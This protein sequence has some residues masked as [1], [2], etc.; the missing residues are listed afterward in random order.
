MLQILIQANLRIQEHEQDTQNFLARAIHDFR[1]PLTSISGY[2][3]LLLEEA[4]GPVTKE[5]QKVLT[6]MQ[7][8]AA[9]LAALSDGIFQL[10]VQHPSLSTELKLEGADIRDCLDRALQEVAPLVE[11]KCI[12]VKVDVTPPPDG[13]VFERLQIEQALLNLLIN[14]CRFTPRE[15]SIDIEGYPAFMGRRPRHPAQPD[16]CAM[17]G[18]VDAFRIDIRDSG[19][20]IPAADLDRIFEENTSYSGGQDRSGAG[21]GLAICRMIVQRHHGRVWAESNPAGAVFSLTL[22][23]QPPMDASSQEACL[24]ASGEN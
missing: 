17:D 15:G 7:R 6:R 14:A 3:E 11:E 16:R 12:S 13:L 10:T 20:G 2:C 22:P 19:P 23:L 5:Q 21:L 24:A 4:L 1:S 9:R 18:E 8:S